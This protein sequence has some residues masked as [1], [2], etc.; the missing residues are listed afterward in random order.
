MFPFITV[1]SRRIPT[2]GLL[3][4][5]GFLISN[6]IIYAFIFKKKN[7]SLYFDDFILLETYLFVFG[8]LGAKILYIAITVYHRGFSIFT[9]NEA[10]YYVL[11]AGFVFYG[12][13]LGGVLGLYIVKKIHH[14]DVLRYLNKCMFAL[15]L[16]HSFGRL[17]CF[18]AACCYGIEYHGIFSV[19][20]PESSLA[21]ANLTLFPVQ[22]LE[23]ILLLCIA[24]ILFI[25]VLK[26]K[27][28]YNI[29][30]YLISYTVVRFFLEYLRGDTVRGRFLFFYTSQ[31]L[32]IIGFI[33]GLILLV[34]KINNQQR[35]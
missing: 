34:K 35:N 18:C 15:P 31:W 16:I 2:Y 10:L 21:P 29:S 26:E 8:F 22:I 25:L 33:A 19:M 17:G 4:S 7:E 6:A 13:I 14:I 32:S 30:I 23:A 28:T 9:N 12:G 1:F 5:L 27:E 3:I 20:F 11:Q 24:I